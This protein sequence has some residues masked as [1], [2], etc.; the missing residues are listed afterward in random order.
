MKRFRS[1]SKHIK[2]IIR[3]LKNNEYLIKK[4]FYIEDRRKVL[5]SVK[6]FEF[7]KDPKRWK[8]IDQYKTATHD[9]IV[10]EYGCKPYEKV[11]KAYVYLYP[12]GEIEN[13]MVQTE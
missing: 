7:T 1:N 12:N 10:C 4:T 9:A 13:V 2:E 6:D 8:K 3:W 11:L 5:K